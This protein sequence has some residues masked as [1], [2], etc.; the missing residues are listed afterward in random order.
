MKNLETSTLEVVYR[1]VYK[2]TIK[3]DFILQEHYK[4]LHMRAPY[5]FI[6][7]MKYTAVWNVK[8]YVAFVCRNNLS[9]SFIKVERDLHDQFV[10][11][12]NVGECMKS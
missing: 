12:E 8:K 9:S 2:R 5:F 10:N 6:C 11:L 3:Q 4:K 1:M 7:H